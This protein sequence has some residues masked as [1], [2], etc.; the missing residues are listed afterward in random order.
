MA[1]EGEGGGQFRPPGQQEEHRDEGGKQH[2]DPCKEIKA[3]ALY[4]CWL[5]VGFFKKATAGCVKNGNGK[6]TVWWVVSLSRENIAD[7]IPRAGIYRLDI[8]LKIY[9]KGRDRA[10]TRYTIRKQGEMSTIL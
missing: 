8:E 7:G 6:Q 3:R 5:Y 2:G 9:P 4:W 1:R 10:N